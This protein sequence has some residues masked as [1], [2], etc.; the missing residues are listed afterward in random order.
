MTKRGTLKLHGAHCASCAYTIEHIGRKIKGIE[1]IRVH[2]GAQRVEVEYSG[3][4]GVLDKVA[5]I[6]KNIGYSADVMETEAP[7]SGP[8]QA[9][10]GENTT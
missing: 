9:P 5:Q 2:S 3:E 1:S 7:V 8:E 10:A 6:V 4:P